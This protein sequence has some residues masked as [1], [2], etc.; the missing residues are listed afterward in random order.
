MT[1]F[2][3]RV[4]AGLLILMTAL[5]WQRPL[6]AAPVPV[7]F[8]EG[9]LHGFL[10]LSTTGDVLLASGDLLQVAR[11]GGV[12]SRLV[13][14]FKDGSVFDETVVFTQRDV[15]TMQSYHLVQRG[16]VFPEDIDHEP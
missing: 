16:P 15:F 3:E 5:L 1:T 6:A 13:F 2:P 7:R 4:A 8:A 12:K 10:V 9:S 14:H 11:D